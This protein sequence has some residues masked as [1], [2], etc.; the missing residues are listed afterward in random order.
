[1]PDDTRSRP[2]ESPE[3][4]ARLALRLATIAGEPPERYPSVW[5]PDLEAWGDRWSAAAELLADLAGRDAGALRA[6]IGPPWDSDLPQPRWRC[7]LSLAALRE[8]KRQ[9]PDIR[10]LRSVK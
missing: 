2:I 5:T 3:D 6:V 10:G 7:L 4:I 8:Q 1:M 9:C